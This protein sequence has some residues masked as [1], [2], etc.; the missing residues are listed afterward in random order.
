MQQTN[1]STRSHE[2]AS[3]PERLLDTADDLRTLALEH[4]EGHTGRDFDARISALLDRVIASE[5]GQ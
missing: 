5:E 3:L 1:L 4:L 2:P